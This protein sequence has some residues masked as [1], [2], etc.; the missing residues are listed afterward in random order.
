MSRD[1]IFTDMVLV[2]IGLGLECYCLGLALIAFSTKQLAKLFK[3]K[4][5]Q[6]SL[7]NAGKGAI[8]SFQRL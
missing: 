6:Y 2:L 7:P 8:N 1:S 5:C 3:V 4:P